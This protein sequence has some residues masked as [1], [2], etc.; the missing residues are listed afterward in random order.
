MILSASLLAALGVSLQLQVGILQPDRSIY[1]TV[2][3][4]EP[5]GSVGVPISSAAIEL[6]AV[7]GGI[8][9]LETDSVGAYQVDKLDAG[10]YTLRVGR[11]GFRELTLQVRVPEQGAVHLDVT[12][13]RVPPILAQPITQGG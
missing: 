2:T 7:G 13:E 1:G 9:R 3:A 12:L 6:T 10:I 5:A 8:R 11:E 4:T